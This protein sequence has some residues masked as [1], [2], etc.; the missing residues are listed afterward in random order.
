MTSEYSELKL[1]DAQLVILSKAA[2]REDGLIEH[3]DHLRNSVAEKVIAALAAKSLIQP[4]PENGHP[5]SVIGSNDEQPRLTSWRIS[6]AGLAAIGIED[7]IV[8]KLNVDV[9]RDLHLAV[10]RAKHNPSAFAS[11]TP[12]GRKQEQLI[13]MLSN[14][15]GVS[16]SDIAS[17]L[18]WLPHTTRAALTGLRHKGYEL[19]REIKSDRGSLYRITAMPIAAPAATDAAQAEA[20]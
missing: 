13:A 3:P 20:A 16:I 10:P 4:M 1:S 9:P 19:G 8:G 14:E 2:Q 17:A 11:T 6:A 7:A 15:E 18:G 5:R 12:R